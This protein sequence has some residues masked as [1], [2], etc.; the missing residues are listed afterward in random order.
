MFLHSHGNISFL[1]KWEKSKEIK[2][3]LFTEGEVPILVHSPKV[4][5]LVRSLKVP[6]LVRSPKVPI[7]VR[8]PKVQ[9]H[10]RECP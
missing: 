2:R 4:P 3:E 7:L 10:S 6:M 1:Q 8:S 5:I 9:E